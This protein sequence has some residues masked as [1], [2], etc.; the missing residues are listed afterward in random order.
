VSGA[1]RSPAAPEVPTIAEAGVPG[2]AATNWYGIAAPAGTPRAI[3]MKLN[4]EIARI[5]ALPDVRTSL[6]NLGMEPE[7]SSAEAFADYLKL[8]VGK[9]ARVV[10]ASGL[11]LD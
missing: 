3:I 10:K 8:E 2:Y 5:L 7:A 1:K 6:L 9:W 11:R 4:Q